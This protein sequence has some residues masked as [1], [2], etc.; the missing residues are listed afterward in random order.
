MEYVKNGIPTLAL[1]RPPPARQNAAVAVMHEIAPHHAD[2]HPTS[3]AGAATSM[4]S[5]RALSQPPSLALSLPGARPRS[6]ALAR[7]GH[8]VAEPPKL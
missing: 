8:I 6:L 4:W 3:S 1:H 2:A 5:A 7:A